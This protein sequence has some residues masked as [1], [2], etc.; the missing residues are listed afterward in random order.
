MKFSY[1]D[2]ISGDAIFVPDV[3]HLNPPRLWQL[4]PTQGIGMWAYN[5]YVSVF[6]WNRQEAI[7]FLAVT[8]KIKTEK[9]NND[10]LT[11]FDVMTLIES[12]RQLLLNALA[13]FIEEKVTW[14]AV[15]HCFVTVSKNGAIIGRID[16]AN[17]AEVSD[18][19]LQ[20]NYIGVGKNNKP[21]RHSSKEAEALW[22]KAQEYLKRESSKTPKDKNMS[23]GNIISKLCA[24]TPAYNLQNIYDLTIFQLYD[25]FF[26]YGY[27]RAMNVNE[28]AFCN[29]GG[30]N[31][32][33]EDWLK[34]LTNF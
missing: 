32:N 24:A 9:L 13:F 33:L 27:L 22:N 7:D 1:E 10:R 15:E 19:I 23:I 26:Q 29:H 3:G 28:M 31:F 20:L 11:S 21:I 16:R 34:P 14:D 12:S 5:L 18:M 8:E 6:S 2:L 17:F 4:K 25:Q 30:K